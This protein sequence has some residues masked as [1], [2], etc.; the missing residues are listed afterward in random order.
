MNDSC[1]CVQHNENS[2]KRMANVHIHNTSIHKNE[3]NE[4]LNAKQNKKTNSN[5]KRNYSSVERQLKL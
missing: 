4:I 3:R 1:M 5:K 2:Q